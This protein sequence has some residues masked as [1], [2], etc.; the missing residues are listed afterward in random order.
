MDPTPVREPDELEAL[1]YPIG[2]LRPRLALDEAER[3]RLTDTIA[4]L[5]V[6]LAAAVDGLTA[7]QLATPY[8][9]GGW[10]LGQVVHHVADSHIN[11]YVRFKLAATEHEPAITTYDEASWARLP[12]AHGTDVSVS[13]RLLDGLHARWVQFLRSLGPDAWE[14]AFVHPELGRVTLTVALQIYGWHSLHH[15]A[16]ITVTRQREGW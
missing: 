8:R 16:H 4:K 15:T 11:S 3:Q 1:R 2:R 10:T 5:P 12:D 13:L 14:R 6:R 7:A 9:P